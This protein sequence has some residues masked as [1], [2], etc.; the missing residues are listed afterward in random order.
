MFE[1]LFFHIF[2]EKH[3]Q[4]GTE[5]VLKMIVVFGVVFGVAVGVAVVLASDSGKRCICIRMNGF[6][7][8]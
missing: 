4:W 1:N 8:L 6:A 7:F 2:E 5:G 3:A